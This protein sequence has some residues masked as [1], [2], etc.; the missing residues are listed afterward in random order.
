[1]KFSKLLS[2]LFFLLIAIHGISQCFFNNTAFKNGEKIEYDVKY[3]W[4]IIWF[5]A[6]F[7]SFETDSTSLNGK[8]AYK[9]ISKGGSYDKY[10]WIYKVRESYVSYAEYAPLKPISYSR[11]SVEGSYFSIEQYKFDYTQ[12][13]L[14]TMVQNSKK[15]LTLDTI[16]LPDCTY[17]LLTAIYAFRNLD[18]ENIKPN[19]RIPLKVV[20]DN[21]CESLYIRMIGKED[22]ISNKRKIPCYHLKAAM[23]E[24][25]IF[26][27]GEQ[28]DIWVTQTLNHIPIYIE[29]KILVGTVKVYLKNYK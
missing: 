20:I 26:H 16:L 22:F 15:P 7:V 24:G 21:V 23:L 18:F 27:A 13:K 17:D 25:T 19:Q 9:F 14:F 29:A 28:T 6:G 10:D 3:S 4:G 8:P 12:K 11:N 1:M 2:V 5:D